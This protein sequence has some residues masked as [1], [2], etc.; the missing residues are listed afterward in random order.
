LAPLLRHTFRNQMPDFIVR[1]GTPEGEIIERH[2]QALNA[3]AAEEDLRRQGMHVFTA[4]RGT[5]KVSDLV[6]RVRKGVSTERFLTFNQEL[7]AL[8]KAGLPIIQS[9]DIMLERQKAAGFREILIDVRDQIKSG[10]ALSDAFASYGDLFPPIYS[11][12]LRAGERSGDLEG[13]LRRF[14]RYQKIIVNLRKKV[15]AALIY[16][17]VLV[18]LSLGMVFV[19]MTYVIPRFAEFYQGFDAELPAFTRIM[20]ALATALRNHIVL[21][22]VSIFLIVFVTRRWIQTA[23]RLL[24]DR[25][26]LHIP[27]VGGILH[28]FAIMQF[29]QSLGTLLSGGTPMVPAIEIASQ[30]VTNQLVSQ[31]IAGIVQNV[32]EGEPLWRSLESTKVVSDL[33]VE[34]IKVGES[35]GALT[36]MLSNVSEFYDEEIEARLARVVAAIEPIILIFMG[37]VIAT[38]LYAFYL[39]LFQLTSIGGNQ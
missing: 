21:F 35:T 11:T 22:F 18:S 14:L 8:V 38:L 27:M 34:M 25:F 37:G 15:L 5:V 29:T 7:L 31:K 28:R 36:E 16:P 13:V 6:R 32:R 2:V 12:S 1:V 23:G 19:M 24:W 39:P 10:V 30:S 9:F 3:R 26:K 4:K 17:A 33:A 20:I